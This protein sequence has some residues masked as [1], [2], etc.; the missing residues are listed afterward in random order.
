[1]AGA[2]ERSR[3]SIPPDLVS[4]KLWQMDN[5]WR[6]RLLDQPR[7]CGHDQGLLI[8]WGLLQRKVTDKL[9]MAEWRYR[10]YISRCAELQG[11]HKAD[12]GGRDDWRR[13]GHG[14]W[15]FEMT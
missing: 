6:G 4:E 5:L 2:T 3:P 15:K 11:E 9:S 1:M 7:R 10:T 12:D 8:L 13:M 14:P